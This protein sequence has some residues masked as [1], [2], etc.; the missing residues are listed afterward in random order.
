[1][2]LSIFVK[3]GLHLA[4]GHMYEALNA[5]AIVCRKSKSHTL[6]KTSYFQTLIVFMHFYAFVQRHIFLTEKLREVELYATW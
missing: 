3:C 1:M 2:P 4:Q 6:P 5:D